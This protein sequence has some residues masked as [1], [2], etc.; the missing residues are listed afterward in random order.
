MKILQIT[1]SGTLSN[2]GAVLQAYALQQALKKLGHDPV[3]I[4]TDFTFRNILNKWYRN[5]LRVVRAYGELRARRREERKH[6]RRFDEFVSRYMQTTPERYSTLGQLRAAP[7]EADAMVTGSDQVWSGKKPFPPYFLAF[8]PE[9]A[10]RFSYAASVGSKTHGG[11][12]YAAAFKAAVRRFQAVSVRETEALEQCRAYGFPEAKLVPDPVL[13]LEP[14]A[15]VEAFQLPEGPAPEPYGLIYLVGRQ[16]IEKVAGLAEYCRERNLKMVCVHSEHLHAAATAAGMEV[17]C[18]EIPAWLDLIRKASL[19]VTDSF[20]GTLF[21]LVFKRRLV[22]VRKNQRDARFD[23]LDALFPIAPACYRGDL[24]ACA[25]FQPDH[26]AIHTKIRELRAE[27]YA[28][29]NE[30]LTERKDVPAIS[31]NG[32]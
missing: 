31:E 4:R 17:A 32:R 19:V 6:P 16:G 7:W 24:A 27:G 18:P 9:K 11:P 1:H 26:E 25:A 2:Y 30:A 3:L 8:G 20:H 13:L 21:S 12:E 22:I 28:F 23:T 5:P 14:E 15:Y 29:L 10:I